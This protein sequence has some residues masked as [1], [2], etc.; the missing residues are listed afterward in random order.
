MVGRTKGHSMKTQ[1][2]ESQSPKRS[3]SYK[4]AC[5]MRR[6]AYFCCLLSTLGFWASAQYSIDWYKISGGGGAST[7]GQFSLSGTIGQHDAGGPMTGGNYALTGGY[8]ALI[9]VVQTPGAPVLYVSHSGNVVIVYWPDIAGWSLQQNNNL[10]NPGGWSAN[11]SW[12][13]SHGT[14]YLQLTSPPG[15]LFFRLKQ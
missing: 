4:L 1:E 6:S 11:S 9:S 14:N 5:G 12:T 3:R 10:V 8:W 2:S 7:N 13:T 15:N